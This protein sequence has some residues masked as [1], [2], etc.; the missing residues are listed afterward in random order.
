VGWSSEHGDLRIPHFL[1]LHALQI[2][3]LLYVFRT[4]RR[5]GQPGLTPTSYSFVISTSYLAFV[6]IATWQAL[7]GQSILHPDGATELALAIWCL[8]TGSAFLIPQRRSDAYRSSA[9]E[10]C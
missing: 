8:V 7:R 4:R 6:G 9:V 10:T 1:G 2:I 3:P 5:G